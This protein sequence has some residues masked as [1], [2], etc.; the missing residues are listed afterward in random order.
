M[1]TLYH[2][3][4]KA[5]Q[6]LCHAR[7]TVFLQS[8]ILRIGRRCKIFVSGAMER[9]KGLHWQHHCTQLLYL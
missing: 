9:E 8:P 6:L 5:E 7:S 3:S 1:E 4:P 2:P